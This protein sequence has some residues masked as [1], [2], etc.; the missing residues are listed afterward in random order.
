V[1]LR[2][3]FASD[4]SSPTSEGALR[5]EMETA[6]R[7]LSALTVTSP[8]RI[9]IAQSLGSPWIISAAPASNVSSSAASIRNPRSASDR[10]WKALVAWMAARSSGESFMPTCYA[11]GARAVVSIH[12]EVANSRTRRFMPS[13]RR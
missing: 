6:P 8:A 3:N 11:K 4:P 1:A 2:G 5:V 13:E 9:S 10:S 12:G 7:A